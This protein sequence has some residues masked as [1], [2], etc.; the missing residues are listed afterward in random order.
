MNNHVPFGYLST[1]QFVKLYSEKVQDSGHT[2]NFVHIHML[3]L[4]GNFDTCV[5]YV[6]RTVTIYNKVHEHKH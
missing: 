3:C 2:I 4:F 6:H 5:T 1:R